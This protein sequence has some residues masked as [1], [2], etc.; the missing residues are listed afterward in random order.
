MVMSSSFI[1]VIS[2]LYLIYFQCLKGLSITKHAFFPSFI[3]ADYPFLNES[4]IL[5]VLPAVP[6]LPNSGNALSNLPML[7]KTGGKKLE[8]CGNCR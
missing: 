1:Y 3:W 7:I 2:P 4:N 8:L 5:L 6:A